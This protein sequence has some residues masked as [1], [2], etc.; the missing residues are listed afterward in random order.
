MAFVRVIPQAEVT[1][2]AAHAPGEP[3]SELT[4]PRVSCLYVSAS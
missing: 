1:W 2:G 3:R 4:H